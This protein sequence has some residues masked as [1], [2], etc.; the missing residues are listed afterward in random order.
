M[1]SMN[2]FDMEFENEEEVEIDTPFLFKEMEVNSVDKMKTILKIAIK[3][4]LKIW[5]GRNQWQNVGP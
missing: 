2:L 3:T 1:A 4:M 5:S